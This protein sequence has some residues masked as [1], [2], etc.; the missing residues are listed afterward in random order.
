MTALAHLLRGAD[1]VS[2]WLGCAPR[3]L[4]AEELMA[5]ACRRTGLAD[6][7]DVAVREPLDA[8]LHAYQTES[9][10]T[11]FGR[12]GARW[13][14]LRYL[15]NLLVL[16]AEEAA[17]PRIVEEPIERPLFITGLPRSGTTFLHR[18]LARDPANLV[19]LCWQTIYPYPGHPALGRSA[20][21]ARV[22]R[23]FRAFERI[24]PEMRSLHPFDAYSPQE[25]T[26]ITAHTFTSLRFDI[27]HEVPS[28]R[29]WLA[30]HGHEQAY[31]FHRRFL[32][33]LQHQTS[34]T[35]R[36]APRWVLKSPDHV[37]AL[38]AI[39]AVYP[40][41]R[42][43]FVHR[44]PLKVLPSDC[45]LTEVLRR[46]FTRRVDRLG[47]G[48]QVS[49]DWADCAAKLVRAADRDGT[50]S[51]GRIFHV[52]YKRLVA[53]PLAT[54]AALYDHFG[55]P[56]SEGTAVAMRRLIAERPRGGYGRNSY[57]FED[58]GL[59]PR[60]EARRFGDY[61]RRFGI[62]LEAEPDAPFA[63]VP[64]PHAQLRGAVPLSPGA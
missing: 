59:D 36:E 18:L 51:S 3:P 37:S 53:D 9:D 1:R 48:A 17:N 41:A 39:A 34:A 60:R 27:T 24:V 56:L 35:R 22:A 25:C 21:P 43:V 2:D 7:G 55:L 42:I 8:L 29:H 54:V 64:G 52:H 61:V 19:P 58:Y 28:Y 33:H 15:S 40:D 45:R 6:F 57:R 47:I 44:D 13:D 63:A 31:R 11:L 46:P 10:L 5:A 62:E 14:S 12:I 49:N 50:W 26:D 30:A 16:S 4:Y 20:G 32:K 38:D 23:Q